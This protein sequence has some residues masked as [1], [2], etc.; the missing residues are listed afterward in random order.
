M[1]YFD[2]Y[3]HHY[4]SSLYG[5]VQAMIACKQAPMSFPDRLAHSS[6][7]N[8]RSPNFFFR[9][10]PTGACSQIKTMRENK[11]DEKQYHFI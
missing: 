3:S 7:S 5:F 11:I 2:F 1:V 4:P 8:S 6:A 9:P 10:C